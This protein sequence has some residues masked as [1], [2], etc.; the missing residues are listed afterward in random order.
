MTGHEHEFAR[1]GAAEIDAQ[2]VRDFHG[3]AVLV[4][5]QQ[6]H[7]EAPTRELEIV[8]IAAEGRDGGFGCEH[9]TNVAE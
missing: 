9:Q 6:A 1:V 4:G 5:T 8:R 3:F 2:R 7:V